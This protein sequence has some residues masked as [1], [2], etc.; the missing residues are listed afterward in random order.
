[1]T[2]VTCRRAAVLGL[3]LIALLLPGALSGVAQ[4]PTLT[5]PP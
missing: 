3:L 2:G 5:P 1:M 4:E